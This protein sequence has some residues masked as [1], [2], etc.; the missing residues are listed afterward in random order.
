MHY[1]F[2]ELHEYLYFLN[3]SSAH[4]PKFIYGE[5]YSFGQVVNSYRVD[6]AIIKIQD[7]NVEG[8]M[9]GILFFTPRLWDPYIEIFWVDMQEINQIK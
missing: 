1:A 3:D 9:S 7:W 6:K 2:F 4:L 8:I 5:F